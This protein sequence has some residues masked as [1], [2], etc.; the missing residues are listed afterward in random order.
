MAIILEWVKLRSWIGIEQLKKLNKF[1]KKKQEIGKKLNEG[2]KNL[3]GLIIPT[4]KKFNFACLLFISS[5][6]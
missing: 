1:V 6:A 2:L 5:K 4:N 3:H